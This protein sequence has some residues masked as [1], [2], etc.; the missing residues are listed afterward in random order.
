MKSYYETKHAKLKSFLGKSILVFMGTI[1]VSPALMARNLEQIRDHD[2]LL[3][4]IG[5]MVFICAIIG[6]IVGAI[7]SSNVENTSIVVGDDEVEITVGNN[8]RRYKTANFVRIHQ[9]AKRHGKA[10]IFKNSLVFKYGPH[11]DLVYVPVYSMNYSMLREVAK[12]I[13]T[14]RHVESQFTSKKR[15]ISGKVVI[16]ACVCQ[17]ALIILTTVLNSTIGHTALI[18][19]LM[20]FTLISTCFVLGLI[21]T[22]FFH[23]Y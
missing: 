16:I 21:F 23:N 3:A 20:L 11:D 9:N 22:Y 15:P 17:V 12:D 2:R 1:S 18:A 5:N 7:S 19:T 13:D 6:I 14:R 10:V 4:V 8:T